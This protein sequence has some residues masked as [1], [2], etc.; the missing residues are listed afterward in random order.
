VNAKLGLRWSIIALVGPSGLP[1]RPDLPCRRRDSSRPPKRE[2]QPAGTGSAAQNPPTIV[3]GSAGGC[4]APGSRRNEPAGGPLLRWK[5]GD[6]VGH[7]HE[8][9]LA[10]AE[11]TGT[12]RRRGFSTGAGPTRALSRWGSIARLKGSWFLS[13]SYQGGARW[14]RTR[15]VGW[16][17]SCATR[18]PGG[19]QLAE[20]IDQRWP[21]ATF[22]QRV[23]A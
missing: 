17:H 21:I 16:D 5:G 10:G 20:L 12:G 2:E 15:Q 6:P 4:G 3:S 11:R 9:S 19:P 23:T 1:A 13:T 22:F 18:R 8:R 14:L 7:H